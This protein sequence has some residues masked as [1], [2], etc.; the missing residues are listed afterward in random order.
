MARPVALVTGASSGIGHAFARALA[1]K[2]H[3][4]VVVARDEAK[5]KEL[6]T[7]V[8]TDV[9]VLPADLTSADD[10]AKVE[11]RLR[12]RDRPVDV[13][14][15]NA[16]YGTTGRFAELP[17]DGEENEIRLNVLAL[18]R[19]TGAAVPGMIERRKGG[20]VNIASIAAFQPTPGTATYGA[21]KA[22]VLSFTMALQGE[23]RG[24]GVKALA[25]CP[26]FTVTEFQKRANYE[27]NKLTSMASQ[28]PEQVAASSLR[29]LERNRGLHVPGAQNKVV[30]SATHLLP[31]KLVVKVASMVSRQI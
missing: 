5:L 27:L 14:V 21:T 8:S 16:G 25:V 6:A 13:L 12:D 3:D 17:I 7:A 22:Y 29:A 11:A 20:V 10:L 31:R 24:T 1:A 30:A 23:L 18:T 2:G 4:L 9:E 28:T 15:N 19:L 26:G